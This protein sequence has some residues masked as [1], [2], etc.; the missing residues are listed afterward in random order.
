[1][2]TFSQYQTENFIYS[3]AYQGPH[4]STVYLNDHNGY[5]RSHI[6][7]IEGSL[8]AYESTTQVPSATDLMTRIPLVQGTL[9]DVSNTKGKYTTAK[10]ESNGS[11]MVIFNPIPMTRKL[12][13]NIIKD[14][15]TLEINATDSNIT[16]VC[17]TGPINVNGKELKTSQFATL[18]Q[19][20]SAVINLEQNNIC[21][22]VSNDI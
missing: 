6:Y 16:I 14:E 21:A 11:A 5:F 13:I 15:Q 8:S 1:M 20:K 10:T 17:I 19:G 12:N 7:M 18:Y 22:L 4:E 2:I 9:Y 3:F